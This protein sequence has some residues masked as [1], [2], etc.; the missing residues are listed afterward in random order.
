MVYR[1]LPIE[2]A[3]KAFE[4]ITPTVEEKPA[5]PPIKRKTIKAIVK[6]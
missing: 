6:K 4:Q 5:P 1:D 2:E 3:T